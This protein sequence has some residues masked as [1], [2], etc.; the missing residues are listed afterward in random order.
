MLRIS[1]FIFSATLFRK[2]ARD[3]SIQEEQMAQLSV[4]ETGNNLHVA[5]T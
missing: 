3:Y 1:I 2:I 4:P 5:Y